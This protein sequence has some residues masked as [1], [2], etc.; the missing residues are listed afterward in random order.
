M[1]K[2]KT[3]PALYHPTPPNLRAGGA[4]T[5]GKVALGLKKAGRLVLNFNGKVR[6]RAPPLVMQLTHCPFLSKENLTEVDSPGKVQSRGLA[7]RE[8]R[9]NQKLGDWIKTT[10]CVKL[11]LVKVKSHVILP[12]LRFQNADSQFYKL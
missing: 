9:Y 3:Q 11:R 10:A 8:A 1:E 2:A 5:L 6:T 12:P 7:M 4:S